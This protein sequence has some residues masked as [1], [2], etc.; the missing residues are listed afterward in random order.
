MTVFIVTCYN[1]LL[2]VI[3]AEMLIKNFEYLKPGVNFPSLG[4]VSPIKSGKQVRAISN[5]D[6]KG[7]FLFDL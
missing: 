6:G 5:V 7:V 3:L 2:N 1:N 4:F